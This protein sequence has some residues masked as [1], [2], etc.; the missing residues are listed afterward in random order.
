MSSINSSYAAGYC[1]WFLVSDEYSGDM[2]WC[3]PSIKAVASYIYCDTYCHPW[4][5][6]AGMSRGRVKNALDVAF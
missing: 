4:S 1:N 5:V 3:P 6:P 2:F